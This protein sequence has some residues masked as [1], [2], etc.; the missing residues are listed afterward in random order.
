[1]TFEE[2]AAKA[3]KKGYYL[4]KLDRGSRHIGVPGVHDRFEVWIHGNHV[5]PY[6]PT[7]KQKSQSLCKIGIGLTFDEAVDDAQ[8]ALEGLESHAA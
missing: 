3:E 7:D 6:K 1:M 5:G 2:M 8:P 4:E